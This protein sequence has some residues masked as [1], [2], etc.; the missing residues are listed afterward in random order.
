MVGLAVR[1]SRLLYSEILPL[2]RNQ[3]TVYLAFRK[4]YLRINMGSKLRLTGIDLFR[5]IAI[6]GVVILHADEGI[7]V[8]LPLWTQIT[9]FANFAVPFFLALS[10]YLAFQKIYATAGAYSLQARLTRLLI[11]Y[12]LWTTLYFL[13]KVLKYTVKGDF[14][15]VFHISRDPL[16]ILLFGG[17]AFQLYFLPLLI[18]GTIATQPFAF[19]TRKQHYLWI[20]LPLWG[21]SL[22]LY[23]LLLVSGN[24]FLND[25]GVAFQGLP[26]AI[27]DQPLLRIG[28]VVVA[29]LLWCLPYILTAMILAAPAVNSYLQRRSWGYAVGMVVAFGVVNQW[30]GLFL[31]AAL[32]E[33]SRGYLAVLGAIALSPYLPPWSWLK[34]LGR[35]AFGIYLI[36]LF[37]IEALQ[38]LENTLYSSG[39]LR[40][41]SANLL[42]FA[43]VSLAVSWGL[44]YG[45]IGRKRLAQW[46]LGG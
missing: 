29:W 42:C 26:W 16:G 20:A 46:L 28:A 18:T 27:T 11:P 40:R 5:G 17:A 13:Y 2:A 25:G 4:I 9:H 24:G 36:H 34:N 22:W 8:V 30:G 44:T 14:A 6:F 21:V 41:S 43:L 19:L 10:F 1:R 31:P 35:C 39:A 45:L 32:Y 3:R 7:A 12:G 15:Q 33:V 23:D 37:V 38:I